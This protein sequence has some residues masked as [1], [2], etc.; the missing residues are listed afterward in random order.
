MSVCNQLG[1]PSCPRPVVGWCLLLTFFY[2]FLLAVVYGTGR[3]IETISKAE[4]TKFL[5]VSHLRPD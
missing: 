3:H 2:F 5:K 4:L 1:T